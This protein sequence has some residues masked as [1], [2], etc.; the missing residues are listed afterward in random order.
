MSNKTTVSSKVQIGTVT[1]LRDRKYEDI[2]VPTGS[3]PVYVE[4]GA[5][6]WEMEGYSSVW[7]GE[8]RFER[9]EP[10]SS[11]FLVYPPQGD[12]ITGTKP[13]PIRSRE[14]SVDEFALFLET[15]IL[16]RRGPERRL[17]F[18]FLAYP[19]ESDQLAEMTRR[20]A[21]AY[22]AGDQGGVS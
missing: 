9:V 13:V 3:Y 22:S 15:D 14:Y 8:A 1:I 16:C 7:E 11:L 18:Q 21:G 19:G 4:N 17:V 10:G 6:Y 20:F 12:V 2:I 5:I